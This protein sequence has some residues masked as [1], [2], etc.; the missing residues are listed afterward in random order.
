MYVHVKKGEIPSMD[1]FKFKTYHGNRNSR[2]QKS[3]T[4][5]QLIKGRQPT[6]KHPKKVKLESLTTRPKA[7]NELN[8]LELHK[9]GPKK[10]TK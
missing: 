5:I 2:L 1:K 8:V 10:W 6:S 3:I 4:F 7:T 9:K